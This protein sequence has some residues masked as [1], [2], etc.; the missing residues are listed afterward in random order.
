MLHQISNR[1][2][3][4][5]CGEMDEDMQTALDLWYS[6]KTGMNVNI[7]LLPGWLVDAVNIIEELKNKHEIEQI[8]K[9]KGGK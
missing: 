5:K 9:S 2:A 3:D 1:I 7:H 6:L 8:E 4:R